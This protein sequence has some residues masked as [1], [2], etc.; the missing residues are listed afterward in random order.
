MRRAWRGS[1]ERGGAIDSV[2]CGSGK[3]G[4]RVAELDVTA[5]E[6]L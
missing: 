6:R 4:G 3:G 5:L 1:K 2:G